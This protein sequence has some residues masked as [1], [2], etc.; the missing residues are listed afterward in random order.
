MKDVFQALIAGFRSLVLLKPRPDA[1]SAP[2]T[3]HVTIYGIYLLTLA[4]LERAWTEGPRTFDAVGIASAIAALCISLALL[5]L[6]PLRSRGAAPERIV[7]G[8][9][10]VGIPMLVLAAVCGYLLRRLTGISPANIDTEVSLLPLIILVVLVV[11]GCLVL[12]RLIYGMASRQRALLAFAGTFL[13]IVSSFI[14]P[15]AGIIRGRDDEDTQFSLLQLA[16]DA[17]R[18]APEVSASSQAP[19]GA[20]IDGEA[21]MMRQHALLAR[22]VSE[23]QPARQGQAEIYFVGFAPYSQQDV[24]K[25]EVAAVTELF[26][27][28][29]GT[30]GRSIILQNHRESIGDTPLASV[31]NLETVLRE[32]GRRMNVE[33]DVLVLFVTSHGFGDVI[34]VSMEGVRLNNLTPSRLVNAL[35]QSGIKNRVLVL[36]ACY[37]GSFVDQLSDDN[38][39]ILTAARADRTSFGCSNEREW[40]FFGDAYF[41]HALRRERSFITAYERARVLIESWEKAQGLTASE[42]QMFVGAAIRDKIDAILAARLATVN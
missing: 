27:A 3:T 13:I 16:V 12:F 4:G 23:L 32:I 39:L 5:C 20:P 24:F 40:T 36:S 6:L 25:R 11:W 7:L 29:F 10:A 42:P 28:R 34:S 9:V 21:L 18:R 15:N 41:N 30:S 35:A 2:L 33:R 22:S 37:S 19:A 31:S 14:L 26:D 8:S 17:L 38:T 1:F